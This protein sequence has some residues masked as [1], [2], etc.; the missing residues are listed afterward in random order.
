[1]EVIS[2]ER[3]LRVQTVTVHVRFEADASTPPPA[4]LLR[5]HEGTW[6]LEG[7]VPLER[8]GD[9]WGGRLA[10]TCCILAVARDERPPEV[11]LA[12]LP[13]VLSGNVTLTAFAQD[14]LGIERV[15]FYVDGA[16]VR[17]VRQAP[18]Q[19]TFD[20]RL[21]D[22][23]AHAFRAVAYD[24]GAN[25]VAAQAQA[26][27]YNIDVI[28]GGLEAEVDPLVIPLPPFVH[29]LGLSGTVLGYVGL[30]FYGQSMLRKWAVKHHRHH[31]FAE[32]PASQ[33]VPAPTR[34]HHA[35]SKKAARHGSRRHRNA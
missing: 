14:N 7:T 27:S 5:A 24:V 26:T 17:T 35:P 10:T 19:F 3:D 20:S 22:N 2:D 1:V 34:R 16:R 30:S 32:E 31:I 11:R 15:E 8:R 28:G 6:R 18:Y 4:L 33:P 23:G 29:V 25:A 13:R 12:S 9:E 21:L